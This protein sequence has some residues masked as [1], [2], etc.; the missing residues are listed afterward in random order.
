MTRVSAAAP[1]SPSSDPGPRELDALTHH[2]A[3]NPAALGAE[4]HAHADVARALRTRCDI[5][6]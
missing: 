5:T 4:R 6:P 1:T 3:L 2:H